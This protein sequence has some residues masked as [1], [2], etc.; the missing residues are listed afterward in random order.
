VFAAATGAARLDALEAE[1]I[2]SVLPPDGPV[3]S[4]Q[5]SSGESGTAGAA[6]LIVGFRTMSEGILPPTSG[7][8]EADPGLPVNVHGAQQ[9]VK[10]R[11]FLVNAI[12]SG[13]TNYS[14]VARAADPIIH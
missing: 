8:A 12:A 13:G 10:S 1:A 9:T 3:A 6:A 14:L 4:S 5:G 11:V 2:R 7:F